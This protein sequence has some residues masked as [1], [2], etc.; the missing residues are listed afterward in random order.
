M[1]KT[2]T[3]IIFTLI[4]VMLCTVGASADCGPKPSVTVTFPAVEAEF[5]VTLLAKKSLTDHTTAHTAICI[6]ILTESP[7]LQRQHI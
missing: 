2:A 5:Y 7:M 1:K 4:A 6:L 3:F